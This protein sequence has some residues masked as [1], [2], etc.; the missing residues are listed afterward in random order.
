MTTKKKIFIGVG[1]LAAVMLGLYIY[2]RNKKG[3]PIVP[4]NPTRIPRDITQLKKTKS[5]D[6][7]ERLINGGSRAGD[8]QENLQSGNA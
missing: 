7:Q 4:W 2:D 6:A 8:L 1:A 3:L 5:Q